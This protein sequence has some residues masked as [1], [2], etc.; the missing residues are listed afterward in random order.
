[1][2]LHELGHVDA[3]H[4]AVVVEK[5]G[6]QRLG[7]FGLAHTRRAK[8]QEAAK[9]PV[10]IRQPGA[11]PPDRAGNGFHRRPLA[12]DTLPKLLFHLQKLFL[13]AFQHLGGRDPGPTLDHLGDLLGAHGFGN[14]RL[15]FATL[16]L[17]Q[18]FLQLGNAP[19]LQLARLGKVAL[20]LGAFQLG[21]RHVQLFLQ[22]A[23]RIQTGAFGLPFR[24]QG[25]RFLLQ[26]GQFLFQLLQPIFGR[27]VVF[28]LQGLGFDLELQDLP[29]QRVQLLGL[30]IHL[31]PQPAG[32]FVHQVNRLVGQEPVGDI[33]MRQR[34][35]RH[36]RAVGDP[37]PVVQFVLFLDP[38]QDAD[39]ILDRRFRHEHRLEPA[40]QSR[41]LFHMLAVFIQRGSTNAVQFPARQAQA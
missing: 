23:R 28:L 17:T 24:R 37:H 27:R 15:A 13:L 40:G 21:P 12:N 7:Q 29:V 2:L 10:F 5:I 3:D 4:R 36:K 20:A 18:L 26:I 38:A 34:C 6:R 9:R 25:R 19:V 32:G 31:H 1:M 22:P 16:S 30:G 11:R 33:T 8:E 14:Q 35:R 41:V 39:R